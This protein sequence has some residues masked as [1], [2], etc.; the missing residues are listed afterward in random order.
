MLQGKAAFLTL[1]WLVIIT[2]KQLCQHMLIP[3]H[4]RESQI[5]AE[6]THKH[7]LMMCQYQIQSLIGCYSNLTLSLPES[8]LESINVALT[9]ESVDETLLCDHSNESYW[10][11]LLSGAVCFW[12]FFKMKFKI[13]SSVLNLA[14]LGVKGLTNLF[15]CATSPMQWSKMSLFQGVE[16]AYDKRCLFLHSSHKMLF[17]N[18]TWSKPSLFRIIWV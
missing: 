8:N 18:I 4:V 7:V 15:G 12:Q 5:G 3:L 2:R 17:N 9:F 1:K 16:W 10:A 14:F 6:N 11:V 13:F